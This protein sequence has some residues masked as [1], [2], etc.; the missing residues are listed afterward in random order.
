MRSAKI[1]SID[2][3]PH[4]AEYAE[5]NWMDR[6]EKRMREDKGAKWQLVISLI[7]AAMLAIVW[8]RPWVERMFR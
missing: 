2:E 1:H 4:F 6:T 8:A 5:F 7:C 3:D